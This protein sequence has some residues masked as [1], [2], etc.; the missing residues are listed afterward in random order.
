M[1][2]K[3]CYVIAFYFGN[4]RNDVDAYQTDR[5]CHL[6]SQIATLEK[7]KHSLSKIIFSFN[8]EPE[9][10]SYLTEAI[11]IIPKRIQNTEIEINIRENYGLSY[12]A[13][14]DIFIKYMDKYD[15]YMFNEDDYVIVQDNFDDYLLNKFKSLPNCGYLCGLVS[16]YAFDRKIRHAGLIGGIQSY[17]C[18][19]KVY[20]K[21]NKL[22]SSKEIGYSNA[23]MDGQVA[24]SVAIRNAGYEIYDIREEY[25]TQIWHLN[26]LFFPEYAIYK[27]FPWRDKD[28]FLPMKV[29]LNENHKWVEDITGEYLRMECDYN[30]TKYFNYGA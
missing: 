2:E 6:K 15:Y 21:N 20:D 14:S 19:K 10:Y 8:V 16:E 25:R 13:F 18:L 23:E 11:N 29:Y 30:S 17:E 5:L 12:G 9:Q 7:Y 22:P 26:Q 3:V 1:K 24:Q 27:F 28:L 4:R